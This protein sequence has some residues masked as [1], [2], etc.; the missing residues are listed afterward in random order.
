[1]DLNAKVKSISHRNHISYQKL[2]DLDMG[3]WVVGCN[4]DV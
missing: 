1:M 4:I 2:G 3:L